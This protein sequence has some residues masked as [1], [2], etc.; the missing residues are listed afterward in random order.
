MQNPLIIIRLRRRTHRRQ[1]HHQNNIPTPPMIFIHTLRIIH[2]AIHP[3]SIK[4]R[5]PHNRLYRKQNIRHQPQN[6]MRRHEMRAPVGDFVVFDNDE[7]GE[8]GEH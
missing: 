5:Y 7:S 2:P 1:P 4:L 6:R 3:G 8:E